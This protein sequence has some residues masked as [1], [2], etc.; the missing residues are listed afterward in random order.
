MTKDGFRRF[1]CHE[2]FIAWLRE[3]GY[4]QCCNLGC[5]VVLSR[6]G[7]YAVVVRDP[8]PDEDGYVSFT[9][10]MDEEVLASCNSVMEIQEMFEGYA[11]SCIDDLVLDE[12]GNLFHLKMT[13]LEQGRPGRPEPEDL[14]TAVVERMEE[15]DGTKPEFDRQ[16]S[17]IIESFLDLYCHDCPDKTQCDGCRLGDVWDYLHDM[18]DLIE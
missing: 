1:K 8:S 4:E 6:D 7:I 2:E 16:E 12:E 10:W 5:G 14:A 11:W 9:D 17:I 15:E 18:G 3:S 13:L